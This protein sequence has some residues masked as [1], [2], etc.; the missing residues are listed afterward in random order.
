MGRG[1]S[2]GD[3]DISGRILAHVHGRDYRPQRPR[4]LARSMGIDEGEYP[5]FREAVK[6]LMRSGRVILG[7]G[8][9]IMPPQGGD[10]VVGRFRGHE[11]GFGFV[12]PESPTEHGDLF[13]P[14]GRTLDAVTGDT[15]VA[16]IVRSGERGFGAG[17][18]E[19]RIV[20]IVARGQSRFVGELRRQG[21]DW[22][23]R[24]DGRTLH[25]PIRIPDAR[26]SRARAG[27]QVVVEITEYPG[28]SAEARGVIV[29]VLGR[30]GDPG[31]DTLSI[32]HE[33]QLPREMPAEVLEEARRVVAGYD[34]Q[35]QL[36][37]RE[38]L[39]DEL[40]ITIDPDEARDFDD[41]ISIRG[42]GDS[43]E[44]GVHIADVAHF[45]RPG[46]ALD[47]EARRR[48]NSVY[49]PRFVIPMLP[50]MLSNGLCS[51]QENE[52]RLTRSVFIQYDRQ[53]RRG[54]IRLANTV[55][56]SARRL[57]Y[58][59]AQAIID[60]R[61]DK[62]PPAVA[63]LLK[64]MD[65]L[66]RRIRQRRL[67]AG[68]IVLDLPEVELVFD[69]DDQVV[70][71]R[72]ADRS[73]THTII[74]MF[75]VEANEAVAETLTGLKVP[76]LRRVHPDPPAD[77]QAKLARF[78]QALGLKPPEKLGRRELIAIL[79]AVRGR[80]EAF[81]ANLAVLRSLAQA[82][83]SPALTG[84]FALASRHYAHFTSPIRR[85]PDLTVHRL[86]DLH[87]RGRLRSR[88]DRPSIPSE[89]E[90]VE[91]GRHCS[92]TER[93][94]EAAERELRMIKVLRFLA[95]RLGEVVEGVVTGVAQVG[96]FVQLRDCLV[97]GLVRFA[98]MADDWWDIDTAAGAAQGQR[99]GR[100]IR[101]GDVVQVRIA[102][103]D[104][105]ARE[106]DLALVD[107]EPSAGRPPRPRVGTPDLSGRRAR[108]TPARPAGPRAS[109]AG[110]TRR[111]STG[112]RPARRRGPGRRRRG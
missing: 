105:S 102:S 43:L 109:T 62:A 49:L 39:R 36:R 67:A 78:L 42:T 72:P 15:V 51:L 14:P 27:D 35:E 58:T 98:D 19:G 22:M 80:P 60:G 69:D 96:V 56:R 17:R 21:R 108:R 25:V 83:Y 6:A 47:E 81:A 44:L 71:V 37:I 89:Q 54:R 66:A 111:A 11:R 92:F 40:V 55:I 8:S 10:R 48:G 97:D 95:G 106:L 45:V 33:Y 59:E 41:A 12:V 84:H 32:I 26:A 16:R 73:F 93:H 46:G 57:T 53:G 75:M 88:Q 18:L 74:E 110:P 23:V 9:C 101:I 104:P 61:D 86:V 4:R 28:R 107:R 70:A 79:D 91:L 94:A 87:L 20:E 5:A 77:A 52:P 90:L 85:Y 64:R 100:R 50:E 24:P 31:I 7:G 29:E 76:H 99:T 1:G 38:D 3:K 2:S 82:E 34:L 112:T 103:V 65:R 68:A 13:I 30:R 63:A